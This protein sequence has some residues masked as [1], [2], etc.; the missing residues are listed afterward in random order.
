MHNPI[1]KLRLPMVAA[2]LALSLVV[3]SAVFADG[4]DGEVG[5][6]GD[7]DSITDVYVSD[8]RPAVQVDYLRECAAAGVSDCWIETRFVSKCP[9]FWCGW[10]YQP[11]RRLAPT[12][13]ARGDCLGAG[14]EEN[15]WFVEY[16]T[17]YVSPATITIK[18]KGEYEL[19]LNVGGSFV[20]RLI[21]EAI[22]NVTSS[23]GFQGGYTI[24]TV[25]ARTDYGPVV[26]VASSG[27]RQLWTC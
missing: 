26:Q 11:W 17:A 6:M 18:W 12:G 4:P 27:G 25:T 8:G 15:Q 5:D 24:E 20:Y 19:T 3:P 21:A 7:S 23:I 14:N 10:G 22:F 9:E 16:R 2:A 1:T 13:A